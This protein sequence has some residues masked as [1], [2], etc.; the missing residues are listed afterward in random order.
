MKKEAFDNLRR[1][2]PL[3]NLGGNLLPS[4]TRQPVELRLAIV[5]G[6]TP[7]GGDGAFL[8]ELQEGG[9][10]RAVV[11]GEP[12]AAGLLNP[13]GDAVTMERPQG[14]ERLQHHQRQRALPHIRTGARRLCAHAVSYGKAIGMMAQL[15]WQGNRGRI[16]N[17]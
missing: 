9:V 15:L 16:W 7:L 4:R 8:L 1:L 11:E 5:F 12:V 14:F 2:L 3:S 13:A 10:E 6:H 17:R